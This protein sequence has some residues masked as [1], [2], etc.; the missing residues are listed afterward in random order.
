MKCKS[1]PE[2][3]HL[4]NTQKN[5][6]LEVKNSILKLEKD[7]TQLKDREIRIRKEMEDLFTK[8]VPLP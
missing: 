8:P 3:E 2:M 1:K 5:K 4:N 6:M 7:F